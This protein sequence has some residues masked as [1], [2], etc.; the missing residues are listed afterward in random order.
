M[1]AAR[2]ASSPSPH[3]SSRWGEGRG[4][5]QPGAPLSQGHGR[6]GVP[7]P[8]SAQAPAPHPNPLPACG[9]RAGVRGSH[10]L[11]PRRDRAC[12]RTLRRRR[13]LLPLTLTLSPQE[14]GEGIPSAPQSNV[15]TTAPIGI[16]S[17]SF[18]PQAGQES[19]YHSACGR[20][21]RSMI[22]RPSTPHAG[23]ATGRAGS[24]RHPVTRRIASPSCSGVSGM[25][26]TP[27]NAPRTPSTRGR[28]HPAPP[29]SP[30]RPAPAGR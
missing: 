22:A 8:T 30:C 7:V 26:L 11:K 4:E 25:R 17:V 12:V 2:A 3:R 9:E 16:W 5:G 23:Q 10:A 6:D 13:K 27:F 21:E 19:A 28:P 14:R 20:A 29:A 15:G 24:I 18:N 1:C